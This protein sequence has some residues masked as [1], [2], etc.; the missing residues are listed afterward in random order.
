MEG[1]DEAPERTT[2]V[3]LILATSNPLTWLKERPL[4]A[5]DWQIVKSTNVFRIRQDSPPRADYDSIPHLEL[6]EVP[7]WRLT[8][9]IYLMNVSRW[10]F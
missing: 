1:A 6:I 3:W 2:H 8:F 7:Q 4:S 10:L 5:F 9:Q